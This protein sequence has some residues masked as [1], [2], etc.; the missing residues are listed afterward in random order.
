MIALST[1]LGH[2]NIAD[3]YWYLEATAT[4]MRGIAEAGEAM[5]RGGDV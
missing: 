5:H 2:T 4:L 1:Y 3:T